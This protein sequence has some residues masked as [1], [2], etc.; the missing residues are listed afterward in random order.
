MSWR[1]V[2]LF[3]G[4]PNVLPWPLVVL[5]LPTRAL[6]LPWQVVALDSLGWLRTVRGSIGTLTVSLG[7][8]VLLLGGRRFLCLPSP[9]RTARRGASVRSGR[10]ST[11]WT[12]R[13][14]Q[15]RSSL[16]RSRPWASRFSWTSTATP[17]ARAWS[18]SRCDPHPSRCAASPSRRPRLNKPA[19]SPAPSADELDT[20]EMS[21]ASRDKL[22]CILTGEDREPETTTRAEPLLLGTTAATDLARN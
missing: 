3:S 4:T 19:T 20:I 8:G 6:P 14:C 18:C 16:T 10:R 2:C 12:S 22:G 5:I 1:N 15:C 17:R 9:P 21:F 7:R 11:S 13:R